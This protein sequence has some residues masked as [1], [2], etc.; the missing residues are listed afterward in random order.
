MA[1]PRAGTTSGS[2]DALST[3]PPS[4]VPAIVLLTRLADPAPLCIAVKPKPT[5]LRAS[6]A[7][8][9]ATS[10]SPRWVRR[11]REPEAPLASH[12]LPEPACTASP[13][14]LLLSTSGSGWLLR[15]RFRLCLLAR[16][17]L[18]SPS[19]PPRPVRHVFAAA[20][21]PRVDLNRSHQSAQAKPGSPIKPHARPK[22]SARVPWS[23]REAP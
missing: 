10:R 6:A 9:L 14:C 17:T 1:S 12:V 15:L 5:L 7:L 4:F 3:E 18:L 11:A 23:C 8:V 19:P 13:S 20:D 21:A 2:D 22:A 16:C